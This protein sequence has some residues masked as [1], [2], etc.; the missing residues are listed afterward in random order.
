MYIEAVP[1]RNSPPAI[2]LRE[3]YRHEGKV[4][5]SG[6]ARYPRSPTVLCVKNRLAGFVLFPAA[7]SILDR[8]DDVRRIDPYDQALGE[9]GQGI[10]LQLRPSESTDLVLATSRLRRRDLSDARPPQG[11]GFR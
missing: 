2:I 4:R 6:R 5:T 8:R 10:L 9:I 7:V 1:N 11:R 3:S